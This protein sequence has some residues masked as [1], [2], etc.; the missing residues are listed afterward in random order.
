MNLGPTFLTLLLRLDS[1]EAR[2]QAVRLLPQVEPITD[3]RLAGAVLAATARRS[4][5]DW[6]RWLPRLDR[7]VVADVHEGGEL[8]GKLIA[9]VFVLRFK[10]EDP[11]SDEDAAKAIDLVRDAAPRE[12]AIPSVPIEEAFRE[13]APGPA[14]NDEQ[15]LAHRTVHQLT[16]A[17]AQRDLLAVDTAS[18]LVLND[19]IGTC[20]QPIAATDG[21]H[22]YVLEGVNLMLESADA[23][24]VEA[25]VSAAS[26]SPWMAPERRNTIVL[27]GRSLQHEADKDVEMPLTSDELASVATVGALAT[28]ALTAWL[29]SFKPTS[30]DVHEVFV[31]LST[32]Q[33]LQGPL[34]EAIGSLA[35]EWSEDERRGLFTRSASEYIAGEAG[36]SLL[37]AY[38]FASFEAGHVVSELSRMFDDASNNAER[39]SVM[40]IWRVIKPSQTAQAAL[41]NRVYI[42]MLRQGRGAAKIALDFFDLVDPPPSIA[43]RDRIRAAI[44][45]EVK[46]DSTLERRA[47]D[48]LRNAGWIK[49][50]GLFGR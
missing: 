37:S 7:K 22:A 36:L 45:E 48:L 11:A 1:K 33:D 15:V 2:D 12:L 31:A 20:G 23:A 18:R 50:R 4:L 17:L 25:M 47:N 19:I 8:V 10:S 14:D 43:A 42:P 13:A 44:R 32:T 35:A 49:K 3:Q 5:S 24:E 39:E 28:R 9:R 27:F 46:G 6:Q 16:Q 40:R 21:L 26:A 30:E 41:V 29:R 34:Q 38:G